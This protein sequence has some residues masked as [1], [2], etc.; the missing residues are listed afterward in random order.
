M[1]D[2][3]DSLQTTIHEYLGRTGHKDFTPKLVL[4]DMDGVLYNSMPSH[5]IAWH[6][7]MKDFG[8][9]MS[10]QEAFLYEGMRGVET[11]KLV[12]KKQWNKD[13]SD[14]EA[15][16][17]Y[18][19]KSE[20]Y[21]AF[22]TADFIPGIHDLQKEIKNRGIE[23]GIVTG[24]GQATLINRILDDFKGLVNPDIIVT[25]NDVKHGKP[26]PDPY[27]QGMKKGNCNPWET[28]VIENAPL[29]VRAGVAAK[30]LTI[31][32][33]TGPLSAEVLKDSGADAV[34][35][36]MDEV[37]KTIFSDNQLWH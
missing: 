25:A 37:R 27:L 3:K 4:F 29:G 23:I 15:Q 12:A 13:L 8:L 31:A 14:E 10:E 18:E 33:N 35:S 32:V 1:K 26:A 9:D 16:K 19:R 11:I 21:A 17:M 20:Y 24:S 2:S 22:P 28:I 30:C 34:F 6:K 36:S 5:A 7:S